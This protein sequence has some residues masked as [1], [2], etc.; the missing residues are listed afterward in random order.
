MSNPIAFKAT[1]NEARN[2]FEAGG[3][4]LVSERAYSDTVEVTKFTTTHSR[5]NTTW[6]QLDGLVEMWRNRYPGQR[7]FIVK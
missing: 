7:Y 6:E 2:H 4:V 3:V 5:E 1:R